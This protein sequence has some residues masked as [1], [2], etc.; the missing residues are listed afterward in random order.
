MT[1]AERIYYE[2]RAP[3]Y[4]DGY[5]GLRALSMRS[6]LDVACGT[7]FL[8]KHVPGRIAALDQSLAMLRIARRSA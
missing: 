8:T 6:V 4:D 7:A 2:R 3:E 5:L 1:E